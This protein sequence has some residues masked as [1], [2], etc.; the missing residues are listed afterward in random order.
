MGLGDLKW[1]YLVK[2][3]DLNTKITHYIRVTCNVTLYTSQSRP[4]C[5]VPASRPGRR[6][7]SK[8]RKS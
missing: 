3:S 7:S 1:N 8:T 2:A 4:G 5:P 6:G